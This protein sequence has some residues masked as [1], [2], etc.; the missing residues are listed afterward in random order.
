M[1]VNAHLGGRSEAR[2]IL[3]SQEHWTVAFGLVSVTLNV[4]NPRSRLADPRKDA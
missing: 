1:M 3:S 4:L 2:W